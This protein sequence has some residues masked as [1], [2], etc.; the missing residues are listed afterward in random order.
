MTHSPRRR[1]GRRPGIACDQARTTTFGRRRKVLITSTPTVKDLSRIEKEFERSDKR[2]F[3]VVRPHCGHRRWLR[4]RGY[5]DDQNDTRA[6]EYR[7]IWLDEAKTAAGYKC[8]GDDCGALIEEFH[9]T[10]MLLGGQWRATAAGDGKTRAATTCRPCIRPSAGNPG[11]KSSKS[12]K[13]ARTTR[14]SSGVR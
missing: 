12:S 9:P 8:S 6:R 13:P 1:R 5:S 14:R 7:L 4:W 3:F 2:R 10:K 11:S